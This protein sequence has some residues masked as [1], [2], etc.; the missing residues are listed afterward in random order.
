MIRKMPLDEFDAM[1]IDMELFIETH[2]NFDNA[3]KVDNM[4]NR[5]KCGKTLS[6]KQVAYLN[7]IYDSWQVADYCD[8][9]RGKGL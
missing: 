5:H 4:L 8:L 9:I 7:R 1:M 2:P 3:E 6:W